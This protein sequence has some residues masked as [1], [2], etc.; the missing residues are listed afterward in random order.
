[1]NEKNSEKRYV[2]A[3]LLRQV[4]GLGPNDLTAKM[5]LATAMTQTQAAVF[6]EA[7]HPNF[8]RWAGR[9]TRDFADSCGPDAHFK[10]ETDLM[11]VLVSE[12]LN[13][14][15]LID[16]GWRLGTVIVPMPGKRERESLHDLFK[17]FMVTDEE[18][19]RPNIAAMAA[20]GAQVPRDRATPPAPTK[21]SQVAR[22]N[23]AVVRKDI[24]AGKHMP[25]GDAGFGGASN[26]PRGDHRGR[27]ARLEEEQRMR[28]RGKPAEGT[29]KHSAK[30]KQGGGRG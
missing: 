2:V 25:S 28:Q 21:A 29:G 8:P 22:A 5:L 12:D 16:I 13:K 23:Q 15:M 10:G 17:H 18:L 26:E 7:V 14:A 27:R 19:D 1:M 30:R 20:A 4:L 24:L 3:A 6:A 11:K 9:S